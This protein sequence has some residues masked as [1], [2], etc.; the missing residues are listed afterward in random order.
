MLKRR[1]MLAALWER[2][3][4]KDGRWCLTKLTNEIRKRSALQRLVSACEA[5]PAGQ[6][7]RGRPCG[8]QNQRVA[9]DDQP[10]LGS[11][12]ST[13][14]LKIGHLPIADLGSLGQIIQNHL[15]ADTATLSIY[16]DTKQPPTDFFGG[17]PSRTAST[18]PK[19][20]NILPC[21]MLFHAAQRSSCIC[22]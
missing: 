13:G 4:R 9:V 14:D 10:T 1:L 21:D 7:S 8:G 5:L 11:C 2:F 16:D 12:V 17:L 19:M 20:R 18:N 6:S 15:V 22:N 3:R